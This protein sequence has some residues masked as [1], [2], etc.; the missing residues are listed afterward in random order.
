MTIEGE[1]RKIMDYC[2]ASCFQENVYQDVFLESKTF[3]SVSLYLEKFLPM[4]FAGNTLTQ[5]HLKAVCSTCRG[6]EEQDKQ[7]QPREAG[8]SYKTALSRLYFS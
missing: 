3:Q 4:F 5:A 8:P 2:V 1:R 6:H 7:S